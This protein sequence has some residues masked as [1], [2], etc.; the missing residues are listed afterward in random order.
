MKDGAGASGLTWAAPDPRVRGRRTHETASS[1]GMTSGRKGGT[2]QSDSAGRWPPGPS[3]AEG[4][5]RHPDQAE[6][7]PVTLDS[8][9]RRTQLCRDRSTCAKFMV[10]T[11]GPKIQTWEAAG[12]EA[13]TSTG[14][15]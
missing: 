9:G 6:A 15:R 11:S 2:P 13:Q 10:G 3:S 1:H 5:P 4:G 14:L 12:E 7:W 8:G